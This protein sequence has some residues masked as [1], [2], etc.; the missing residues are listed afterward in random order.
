MTTLERELIEE[1]LARIM[2]RL[3]PGTSAALERWT[4]PV[5]LIFGLGT[6]GIRVASEMADGEDNPGAGPS[7]FDFA[8]EPPKPPSAER[9]NGVPPANPPTELTDQLGAYR[10]VIPEIV[11]RTG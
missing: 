11:E 3:D 8:P 9:D 7:D 10:T 1:P 6:W 4:D 5:L 2:A